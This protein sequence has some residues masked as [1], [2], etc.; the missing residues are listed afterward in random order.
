VFIGAITCPYG[1]GSQL[2]HDTQVQ[3]YVRSSSWVPL[4][5]DGRRTLLNHEIGHTFGFAEH[6]VN[7]Y[8]RGHVADTTVYAGVMDNDFGVGVDGS[9]P[10]ANEIFAASV[11]RSWY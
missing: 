2:Y 8:A 11:I 5:E 4:P 3:V 10:S 6:Y 1:C 9:Y 7:N